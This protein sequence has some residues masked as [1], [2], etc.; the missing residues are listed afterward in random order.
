MAGG[1]YRPVLLAVLFLGAGVII[2]QLSSVQRG[3]PPAL[4]LAPQSLLSTEP[5]E[6]QALRERLSRL[7]DLAKR[8]QNE[9]SP[10]AQGSIPDAGRKETQALQERISHLEG[11]VRALQSSGQPPPAEA[12]GSTPEAGRKKGEGGDVSQQSRLEVA[13]KEIERLKRRFWQESLQPEWQYRARWAI[14][15]KFVVGEHTNHLAEL[16]GSPLSRPVACLAT[17]ET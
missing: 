2:L 3:A 16:L 10:E 1:R 6:V 4:A 12:T 13:F 11:L 9:A 17:I 14:N 15:P 5:S 8:Q 7:E